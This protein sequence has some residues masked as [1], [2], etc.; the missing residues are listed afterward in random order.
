VGRVASAR[1]KL[2]LLCQAVNAHLS[3]GPRSRGRG[4]C[5]TEREAPVKPIAM[6]RDKCRSMQATRIW[7]GRCSHRASITKAGP[8]KEGAMNSVF[9]IIGVVVVVL[10][11]LSYFGLR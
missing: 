2:V 4:N 9:Y 5:F 3:P 10:V 6:A 8:E 1:I 11:V 7:H